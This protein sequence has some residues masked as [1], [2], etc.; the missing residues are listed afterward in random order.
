MLYM[1]SKQNRIYGF[2]A[3]FPVKM[4]GGGQLSKWQICWLCQ[5]CT[6]ISAP[7]W[8]PPFIEKRREKLKHEKHFLF[9]KND[10]F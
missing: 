4:A 8:P 6:L 7:S 5:F 2:F 3:P 9:M 10:F 1:A